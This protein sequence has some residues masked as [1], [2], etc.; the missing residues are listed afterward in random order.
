MIHLNN[1]VKNSEFRHY[2]VDVEY[3]R[4]KN[5]QVKTFLKTIRGPKDIVVTINCDLIV[6]SRGAVSYTH[7]T[8]PTKLL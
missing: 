3:N 6:H 7:L 2:K 8:L 1:L 5:G 4:N